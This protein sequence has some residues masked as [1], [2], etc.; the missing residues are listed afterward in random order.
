MY[1]TR[2]HLRT[3]RS[4]AT[5]MQG[6][7]LLP[8]LLFLHKNSRLVSGSHKCLH[9]LTLEVHRGQSTSLAA[10]RRQNEVLISKSFSHLLQ[11]LVLLHVLLRD[12]SI[13][14]EEALLEML[15]RNALG[16]RSTTT[17]L[18]AGHVKWCDVHAYFVCTCW[19]LVLSGYLMV[20]V[21]LANC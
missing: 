8:S 9:P 10:W 7:R 12:L 14:I 13:K 3:L 20:S 6:Y 17:L 21:R 2:L 15:K 18:I 11:K 1:I 4:N 5:L 16:C 19:S